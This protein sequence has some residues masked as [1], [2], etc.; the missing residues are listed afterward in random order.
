MLAGHIVDLGEAVPSLRCPGC[1]RSYP[2]SGMVLLVRG[3]SRV[4]LCNPCYLGAADQPWRGWDDC[5]DGECWRPREVGD[6]A[7]D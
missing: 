7:A 3:R 2:A 6:V 1:G 4:P 5:W